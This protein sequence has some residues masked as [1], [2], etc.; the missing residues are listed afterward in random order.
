MAQSPI[1]GQLLSVYPCG[2]EWVQTFLTSS[3]MISVRRQSVPSTSL[4]VTQNE[5]GVAD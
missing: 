5:E 2:Q 4:L 3:V 1:G